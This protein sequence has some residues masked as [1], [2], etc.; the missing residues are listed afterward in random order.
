[1]DFA[2]TNYQAVNAECAR[3]LRAAILPAKSVVIRPLQRF[4]FLKFAH[5]QQ[6]SFF[7]QKNAMRTDANFSQPIE[8]L[9]K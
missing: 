1:M 9:L 6:S 2:N 5:V 8:T 3:R 4:E 7:W